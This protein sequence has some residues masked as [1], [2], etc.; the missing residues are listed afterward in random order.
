L[1]GLVGSGLYQEPWL[2]KALKLTHH[3]LPVVRQKAL[4][5]FSRLVPEMEPQAQPVDEFA[6]MVDDAKEPAL[7]REAALLAFSYCDHPKV[8]LKLHTLAQQLDHPAWAAA[9]SRL[10]DIGTGFT[11][12]VLQQ[13]PKA[14]LSPKNQKVL[15]HTQ[16][17][18]SGWMQGLQDPNVKYYVRSWLEYAAWAE[19]VNDPLRMKL[20]HWTKEFFTAVG[21]LEVENELQMLQKEYT[22]K[23]SV[24]GSLPAYEARVQMLAAAILA[25]RKK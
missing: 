2:G 25:A 10:G 19:H 13:V 18:V 20:T 9:V 5:A 24:T 17:V 8:F 3:T 23:F 14:K 6:A 21:N 16:K 15:E 22:P 1:Q 4:L 11:L 7:V 12:Q